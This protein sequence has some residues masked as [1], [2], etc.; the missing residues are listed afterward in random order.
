MSTE[1]S[2]QRQGRIAGLIYLGVVVTGIFALAYAPGQFV[3]AG[4]AAAT[5][6]A[7][8]EKRNLVL[9]AA[10]SG[11]AMS[12]FFLVLPVAL[13]QFLSPFG[14]LSAR[15]MTGLVAVST[16]IMLLAFFQYWRISGLA[17]VGAPDAPSV[18]ALLAKYKT[19]EGIA[20]IFWGL[21][22]APLGY[23]V[24]KSGAIPRVLGALLLC[25]FVGYV[26]GYFGPRLYAG[27][28]DLPLMEYFSTLG[29]VGEIG[30][31]LW[32]LIMGARSA[33]VESPAHP[34]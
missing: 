8:H 29:S 2:V 9:G 16:P 17:A 7:M 19:Y 20:S 34:D 27:Y 26:A 33:R 25:G 11:L 3:I 22:L 15:L 32:L 23:L 12:A 24:L 13:A 1:T 5:A 4:D 14:R 18:S 31:C 21:W 10:A 30:T 28:R 6:R